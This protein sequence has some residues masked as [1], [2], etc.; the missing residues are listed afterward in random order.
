MDYLHVIRRQVATVPIDQSIGG[1]RAK[2]YN[3]TRAH[4]SIELDFEQIMTFRRLASKPIQTHATPPPLEAAAFDEFREPRA[5]EGSDP[6]QRGFSVC[7]T[8]DHWRSCRLVQP[9]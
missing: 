4:I 9:S 7:N 2:V 1:N 6:A 5:N 3:E 8:Q